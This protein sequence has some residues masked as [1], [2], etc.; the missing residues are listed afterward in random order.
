MKAGKIALAL[1]TLVFL[2]M[3]SALP[4]TFA[5]TPPTGWNSYEEITL[6]ETVGVDRVDEPVDVLFEPAFGECSNVS[7]IRV[8]GPDEVTEVPSQVYDVVTDSGYITSCRVVFLADCPASSSVKYYIIYNNPGVEAPIYDGLRLYQVTANI[9]VNITQSGVEDIPYVH[10]YWNS[11]IALYSNGKRVCWPGGPSGQEFFPITIGSMWSDYDETG[12]F[13][14]NKSISVVN[15]GPVFV[16]LNYTEAGASDFWGLVWDY[17]VTTTSM[18]RIYYQPN[19]NPLLRFHKTF[20]IKTNLANYTIRTP[21]YMD[22]K[23]ANSTSKLIYKYFN[24]NNITGHV[25]TVTTETMPF[26]GSQKIWSP[27]SPVGWWSFH[28]PRSDSSDWPAANIGYIPTNCNGTISGADYGLRLSE[29]TQD[30][31]SH[32]SQWFTGDFNGVYGDIFETTGYIVT[33]H[34]P[35]DVNFDWIVDIVDI[36]I[37]ALA[38]GSKP[39]DDNWNPHADVAPE[40]NLIDIVDI[41]SVAIHFG[42]EESME[43]KA[44]QLRNPLEKS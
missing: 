1:C 23:L 18:I 14:A 11:C 31:D 5:F 26:P 10:N 7:E 25:N 36:V 41:V 37:V 16:D 38:F 33:S 39:G 44:A 27:T 30:D 22:F 12:W 21:L 9:F 19:L 29:L 4:V 24:W 43:E 20:K 3:F 13:G 15:N 2:G 32:C 28:G 17:N 35:G 6:T 40:F 42:E 34:I 8:I